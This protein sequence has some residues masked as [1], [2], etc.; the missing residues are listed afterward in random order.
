[1]VYMFI[2]GVDPSLK[3]WKELSQLM[4][5]KGHIPFFD[6]AYQVCTHDITPIQVVLLLPKNGSCMC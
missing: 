6:C 1:V 4:L 5:T 2:P 3:Q